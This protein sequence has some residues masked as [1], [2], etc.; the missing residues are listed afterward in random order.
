M[1]PPAKTAKTAANQ[2]A[3]SGPRGHRGHGH[4]DRGDSD[5]SDGNDRKHK[6]EAVSP[7]RVTKPQ[8]SFVSP[9]SS[10]SAAPAK[11][12]MVKTLNDAKNNV[13]GIVFENSFVVRDTLKEVAQG[14]STGS[15]KVSEPVL[16]P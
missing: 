9:A 10:S 3:S 4:D 12:V 6:S 13:V 11:N 5:D 8:S 15:F 16:N 1:A 7:R 14:F 2:S